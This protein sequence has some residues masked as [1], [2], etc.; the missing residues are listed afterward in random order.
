MK[1]ILFTN[2]LTIAAFA[3]TLT[4]CEKDDICGATESTTPKYLIEFYDY[5]DQDIAKNGIVEAYVAGRED[6]IIQSTSNQ[7]SLPLKLDQQETT[8]ILLI[9]TAQD[10]ETI[11]LRDTLTLKY[12]V[13]TFYLNKACGYISTFSL[14]QDGTSPLLNGKSNTTT[15]NWI[16]QY[17]T[18]TNEI[19]NEEE[20]HFKIYY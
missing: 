7:L 6:E 12:R 3:V 15:G 16:K 18:E 4:A 1:K 17:V 9:K 14:L 5:E 19:E 13:N 8:W 20:A 11:E 10:Q 2:V